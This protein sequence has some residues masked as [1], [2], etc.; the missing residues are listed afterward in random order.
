[1]ISESEAFSEMIEVIA[2]IELTESIVMI[3]M[4]AMIAMIVA[5][6]IVIEIMAGKLF[7]QIF[8]QTKRRRNKYIAMRH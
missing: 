2:T 8:K 7:A 4:I 6:S 1:M 5:H 3:E